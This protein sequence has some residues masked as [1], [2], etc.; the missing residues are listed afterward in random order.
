MWRELPRKRTPGR[1]RA[2]C[3]REEQTLAQVAM[4]MGGPRGVAA[5]AATMIA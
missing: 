2:Y 3:Q 4:K 5:V 1:L